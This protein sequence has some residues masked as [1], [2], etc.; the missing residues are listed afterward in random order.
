[1]KR[2]WMVL[3]L[4]A[5]LLLMM[6]FPL[7]AGAVTPPNLI[8]FILRYNE[9]SAGQLPSIQKVDDPDR[10]KTFD[11]Y[12]IELNKYAALNIRTKPGELAI[13]ETMVIAS[14]D[15]SAASGAAIMMTIGSFCGAYG[16]FDRLDQSGKYFEKIG[17]METDALD[18]RKNSYQANGHTISFTQVKGLGLM[19]VITP[20]AN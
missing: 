15:G 10:G 4:A 3:V 1:M 9:I 17:L 16:L 19:F 12:I 18:G 8:N 14:G 20:P 7:V 2:R 11:N 6:V 13:T 5:L